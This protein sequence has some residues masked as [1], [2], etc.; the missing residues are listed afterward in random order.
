MNRML[1]PW[2]PSSA[3]WLSNSWRRPGWSILFHNDMWFAQKFT[4]FQVHTIQLT[5]QCA[6]GTRNRIIPVHQTHTNTPQ[7]R[8]TAVALH[9]L[10]L[11]SVQ[12]CSKSIYL[13]LHSHLYHIWSLH[14]TH[15]GWVVVHQGWEEVAGTKWTITWLQY[16]KGAWSPTWFLVTFACEN[17]PCQPC[18][19]LT[20]AV[21]VQCAVRARGGMT[22]VVVV[23]FN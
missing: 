21:S 12:Y 11:W 14:S 15:E 1:Q 13:V 7:H 10:L 22:A 4:P 3:V 19:H 23:L 9:L 16:W 8:T 17:L 6:I 5:E 20:L 18:I 2:K